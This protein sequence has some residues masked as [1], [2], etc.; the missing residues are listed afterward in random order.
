[1]FT[2][3]C[4]AVVAAYAFA[5]EGPEIR[6]DLLSDAMNFLPKSRVVK[7]E[8]MDA[9][10]KSYLNF[11]AAPDADTFAGFAAA[12]KKIS[13]ALQAARDEA[14][15]RMATFDSVTGLPGGV[16]FQND[17]K[18]EA[19]RLSRDGKPFCLALMRVDDAADLHDQ[20]PE[21]ET[22][23]ALRMV[24]QGIQDTL[25]TY[26][27]TY[28]LDEGRFMLILKQSALAES[29]QVI[30]RL[31]AHIAERNRAAEFGALP[32]LTLSA[33]LAEPLRDEDISKLAEN[34]QN[35]LDDQADMKGVILEHHE[36]SALQRYILKKK[37]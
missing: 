3:W 28:Y 8:D 26:D 25:R 21:A 35:D 7:P 30:M 15:C 34:M 11:A 22:G 10:Q 13:A 1:M 20:Y 12:V 17:V 18:K 2:D 23:A 14:V 9:L 6:A 16:H 4:L 19:E 31:Q 32:D 37:S 36:I 5:A 29:L 33:C 24:A 27:D